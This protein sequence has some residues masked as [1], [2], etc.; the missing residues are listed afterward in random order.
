MFFLGLPRQVYGQYTFE[1]AVMCNTLTPVCATSTEYFCQNE[2]I[3]SYVS[4]TD[5]TEPVNIKHT[6]YGEFGNF[7]HEFITPNYCCLNQVSVSDYWAN[8]LGLGHYYVTIEIALSA[9]PN[10][11]TPWATNYFSVIPLSC[12]PPGNPVVTNSGHTW[13]NLEWSPPPN[14]TNNDE[15]RIEYREEGSN[16]W[17]L[18]GINRAVTLIYLSGGPCFMYNITLPV[19]P[20][21]PATTF[22]VKG[23]KPCTRYY[24][25]IIRY[26]WKPCGTGSYSAPTSVT[27]TWTGECGNLY[28][29]KSPQRYAVG[30]IDCSI[31]KSVDF[32]G[33]FFNNGG[34]CIGDVDFGYSFYQTEEVWVNKGQSYGL[35]VQIG[36]GDLGGHHLGAWIDFN[37]NLTFESNEKVVTDYFP[38]MICEETGYYTVNIPANALLGKTRMRLISQLNSAPQPHAGVIFQGAKVQDLVVNIL[39]G[40]NLCY[41][42]ANA[43]QNGLI[44]HYPYDGSCNDRTGANPGNPFGGPVY[45]ADRT[46]DANAA[47]QFDG[48]ND[49]VL[50]TSATTE[51][52]VAFWFRANT[53]A[54]M[55]VFQGGNAGATTGAGY[56]IGIYQPGGIPAVNWDTTYG[57]VVDFNNRGVYIPFNNIVSGWRHVAVSWDGTSPNINVAIDGQLRPGYLYNTG[58]GGFATTLSNQPFSM[59]SAPNP[60]AAA[61][62]RLGVNFG[63]ALW[64]TGLTKLN[65]ALDELRIYNRA[66]TGDEMRLLAGVYAAATPEALCAGQTAATLNCPVPGANSYQWRNLNTGSAAGTAASITP[67]L[68]GTTSFE[69]T[70]VLG[71]CTYT[72]TVT[73]PVLAPIQIGNVTTNGLTGSFTVSGGLPGYDGSAYASVAMVLQGNPG[74]TATLTGLP[75]GNGGTVG[76]V[77]PE[78]GTFTLS[79]GDINGCS[80]NATVTV[81][82]SGGGGSNGPGLPAGDCWTWQNPLPQGN[83]LLDIFFVDAQ[84]G[85]A[86]GATGTILKTT[87]GGSNWFSQSSETNGDLLS[88]RFINAQTGWVV[89]DFGTILKTINGGITWTLQ[90]SG[91]TDHLHSVYFSDVQTGWAVGGQGRILKTTNGGTNWVSQ[92]SGT[93]DE[94]HSVYFENPQIGWIVGVGNGTILSTI[95]GGNKWLIQTITAGVAIE[96]THFIDAQTGWAVGDN[97]TI[98]KTANGGVDW[99]IQASGTTNSILYSVHFTNTQIG[100]VVGGNGTILKTIDGG[101]TWTAQN[102]NMTNSLWSVY[103]IDD[104]VGWA[105]G[106]PMILKTTDGGDNWTTQVSGET[107][108]G[109]LSVHFTDMQTGWAVG[110]V[111]KFIM[112]TSNSGAIW[113]TENL[114]AIQYL[115]S[116]HFIDP[117]TGW[118]VGD[119]GKILKT[120]NGGTDWA[121][122]ISGATNILYSVHFANIQIGW[123]VGSNGTILKTMDGGANWMPQASGLTNYL[124]AVYFI[125]TQTGWAVGQN[126]TIL[127]TI[128][129]GDNW[130]IQTSS[131]TNRLYSVYFITTQIGYAVGTN[132]IILKTINSGANWTIQN[133]M[134]FQDLRSVYFI[135]SQNGWAVGHY[136]TILKTV[137]GGDIWTA[138]TLETRNSFYSAYFTDAQTG[139]VVGSGGT[140]LK[141]TPSIPSC[142][143]TI[144]LHQQTTIPDTVKITWPEAIG[145]EDGYRLSLSTTPGGHNLLDSLDVG[146]VTT[147]QPAQPLPA[148]DTIYVRITPYNSL[149]AAS[150]CPEFWFV[151]KAQVDSVTFKVSDETADIGQQICPQ[152]K[153]ENFTDVI[154]VQMAIQFDPVRLGYESIQFGNNPLGLFQSGFNSTGPGELVFTWQD[155]VGNTLAD[156]TVIFSVCFTTLG[157]AGT[158]PVTLGDAVYLQLPAEIGIDPTGPVVPALYAG[159]VTIRQDTVMVSIDTVTAVS[160][161]GGQNGRI[162]I[163]VSGGIGHTFQWAGPGIASGVNDTQEDPTGLTAGAYTVTVTSASPRARAMAPCSKSTVCTRDIGAIRRSRPSHPVWV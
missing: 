54:Q 154:S 24:F 156:S 12:D 120:T 144:P 18:A 153:V 9:T 157:P 33:V 38:N 45:T 87:D 93:I 55:P 117:Q 13:V 131:T 108:E 28:F 75:A 35:T 88:V 77:C 14:V 29:S 118:A 64:N 94:L 148:G 163:S 86:V 76:F 30:Y 138:Q 147:Y 59:G 121:T 113:S 85:W 135:S 26:C 5:V 1:K 58:T 6:W 78:A 69:I 136:G 119:I 128:D 42:A 3:H 49:S 158:T 142:I 8:D 61:L 114:G 53:P 101:T 20:G 111:G 105:V 123:A 15:Y 161:N 32:A 150:G 146:N 151:T 43:V 21:P 57:L 84:T 56:F 71:A 65:G 90:N 99:L 19:P 129:G 127:K 40:G 68:S 23:L 162:D 37:Q 96:S 95:D 62:T 17:Q 116:V 89:G 143:T 92:T 10:D 159:S 112:K 103:F 145:C 63:A 7:I 80:A 125:D 122:Q 132:G 31:I 109:F 98:L 82:D 126:G 97:G 73:V 39:G 160:C 52:S 70:A 48:I 83:G 104:Q 74:V 140:I 155:I 133:S 106:G 2:L 22:Q 66:L 79:A 34:D 60:S 115:T 137:N 44:A 47:I 149:G 91:V 67:T 100:W 51:R 41:P 46:G 141:Y 130:I 81:S 152:V 4:L 27:D 124:Y 134:T 11:Y 16:T 25:R 102:S 107:E 36:G 50:T 110:G 72:D 139:W